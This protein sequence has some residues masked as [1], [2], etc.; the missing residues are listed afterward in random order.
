MILPPHRV[1]FGYDSRAPRAFQ[2]CERSARK[3]ASIPLDIRR[4]DLGELREAGIYTRAHEL[5]EGRLWDLLSEQPMST[6]FTLTRFLVPYLAGYAGWALYADCDFLWRADLAELFAL[7]DE[8][9]ALMVVKHQYLAQRGPKMN[10]QTNVLYLRKNWSSLMLFNCG[11]PSNRRLTPA[12]VNEWHRDQLHAFQ[13][14]HD[15]E[16]GALPF[17]W[18]WLD[19]HPKAVHFTNGTPDLPGYEGAAYADEWGDYA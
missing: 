9:C 6:E 18:N 15:W 10:G 5:R 11:H 12:L 14:L 7:A 2:V 8:R 3:H 17:E 13:W 4:L 1:F 19:L 16:I